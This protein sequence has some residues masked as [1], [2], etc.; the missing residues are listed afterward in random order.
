MKKLAKKSLSVL[1]ALVFA[2]TMFVSAFAADTDTNGITYFYADIYYEDNQLNYF[3]FNV[4]GYTVF[5]EDAFTC[6][7]YDSQH[8]EVFNETRGDVDYMLSEEMDSEQAVDTIF[9]SVGLLDT[10]ILD[11]N[12]TYTLVVG[13]GSFSTADE[14]LS[15]AFTYSFLASDFIYVP[16]F[17]DRVLSFLH[18]NVVFEFIFARLII[19]IE[20]FYY[21]PFSLF[22][23]VGR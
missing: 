6:S 8:N 2:T 16:T 5:N 20:Y 11:P 17:W 23:P 21:G 3:Y 22:F 9:V 18:A 7:L 10:V 13:A 1:L 4:E 12:E 15:P 19:I 14:Q